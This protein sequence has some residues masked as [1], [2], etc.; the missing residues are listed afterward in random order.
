MNLSLLGWGR[1]LGYGAT[2][3]RHKPWTSIYEDGLVL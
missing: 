3:G 2:C 1:M